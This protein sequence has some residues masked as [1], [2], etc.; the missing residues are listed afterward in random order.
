MPWSLDILPVNLKNMNLMKMLH[1]LK[2]GLLPAVL[3]GLCYTSGYTQKFKYSIPGL[4]TL[5]QTFI[6]QGTASTVLKSGQAEIISNNFI[7]SYWVAFHQN[8]DNS[9][10]L[11]RFRKT[12]FTADLYGYYG[13]SASGRWDVGLHLKYARSRLDNA[14]SSS[15][16]EVFDKEINESPIDPTFDPFGIIDRSFGGLASVGLRV[17]VKPLLNRPE[18][19]VT[20]G[21]AFSTVKDETKQ[22]QLTADRD[23]F[24]IGFSYY[25]SISDNVFYFLSGLGQM[26]IPSSVRDESLYTSSVSF[27]LIHRSN[28]Y[29]WTFYPGISYGLSF[30]PSE[31]DS[32]NLIKTNSSL[33]ALGGI[34]YAPN[35]RYNIFAT[36]GFPLQINLISPLQEIVRESYSL[37]ALGF[38]IGM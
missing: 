28:N 19:I 8:G 1:Y 12:Q 6:I 20:G 18:F 11:D 32:H 25:R 26:Y 24:D 29:K 33:F 30:K 14:A 15:M 9:P 22:N 13:I 36:A 35:S 38:R 2:Y 21:Y 31:F 17:R 37:L 5:Q 27:Y 3:L 16:L 10:V 7:N 23:I 34:Q 4:D